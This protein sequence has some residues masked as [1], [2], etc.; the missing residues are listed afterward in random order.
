MEFFSLGAH[1]ETCFEIAPYG[2]NK[3]LCVITDLDF[4]KVTSVY[5]VGGE[6]V[7]DFRKIQQ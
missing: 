2:P 5:K 6:D 7:T 3:T 4:N 1:V